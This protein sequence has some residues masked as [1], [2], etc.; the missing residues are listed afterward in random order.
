MARPVT[1]S[2]IAFNSKTEAEERIREILGRYSQM[3]PLRG[4][5]LKFAA[6]ILESHPNRDVIVDCGV[7]R[8]V[9]QHLKDRYDSRRFL[10]VRM[11]SSVRDFTWRHALYPKTARSRVMK[12]CRY[13]I[14]DQIQT[15]RMASFHDQAEQVCAV[16]GKPITASNSDVDHIPP[17]TFETLV[18]RWLRSLN[19]QTQDVALVPVVG[20]EQPDRWEDTFLEENWRNYHR[21]HADLRVVHPWANR[22]I[23]RKA[24]NSGE[25]DA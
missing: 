9:V 7:K 10:L 3:E 1:I 11:D 4:D 24:A 14:K 5:D 13:A 17:R 12:A 18:E 2:G 8:I 19:I 21:T 25:R 20:Y 23:V 15:F 6:A 22:S 16:S